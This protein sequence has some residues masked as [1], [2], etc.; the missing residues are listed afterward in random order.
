MYTKTF[1]SSKHAGVGSDNFGNGCSAYGALEPLSLQLQATGHAHTHVPTAV[2]HRVDGCLRADYA[3]ARLDH[4]SI[5]AKVMLQVSTP[6]R[7]AC[8]EDQ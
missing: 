4:T 2:D 6:A 3:V 7:C 1:K 5:G 8:T